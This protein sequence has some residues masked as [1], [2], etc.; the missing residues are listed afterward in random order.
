VTAWNV[1]VLSAAGVPQQGELL[2]RPGGQRIVHATA[3]G[4]VGAAPPSELPVSGGGLTFSRVGGATAYPD[5]ALLSEPGPGPS[6]GGAVCESSELTT[7]LEDDG[8]VYHLLRLR[9]AGWLLPRFRVVVPGA[10]KV[11]AARVDGNWLDRL[12]VVQASEQT[13]I[14]LAVDATAAA[15]Q[16]E[17][18]YAPEPRPGGWPLVRLLSLPEPGLPVEPLQ[19]RHLW[20]LPADWVPWGTAGLRPRGQPDEIRQQPSV[21]ALLARAWHAGGPL[22]GWDPPAGGGPKSPQRQALLNAEDRLRQRRALGKGTTLGEAVDRLALELLPEPISLVIDIE[23][24]RAEGLEPRSPLPEGAA[25]AGRPFADAVGLVYVFCPSGL[26]LTTPKRVRDWQEQV[27]SPARLGEVLDPEV[28]QAAAVG[29]DHAGCFASVP[30]WLRRPATAASPSTS[31]AGQILLRLAG[32]PDAD[33]TEW[34]PLSG[35]RSP[36][37]LAVIH[38]PAWRLIGYVLACAWVLAAWA[39]GRRLSPAGA[40]R[41]HLVAFGVLG[42]AVLWLPGPPRELVAAPLLLAEALAFAVTFFARIW[43][44]RGPLGPG[45]STMVRPAGATALLALALAVPALV[46]QPPATGAEPYPVYL[47]PGAEGGA[48]FALVPPELLKKLDEMEARAGSAPAGGVVVAARYQG[49]VNEGS[50]TVEAQF[51]LYHFTEKSTFVLPLAGVNL[52]KGVF[53]DGFPAF[54]V[55]HKGGYALPLRGKGF[56]RLT[57]SFQAPAGVV[58]D[59]QELHFGV[60]RAGQC[61]L[62][63][64]WAGPARGIGLTGGLGAQQLQADAR[65]APTLRAQL[66]HEGLVQVRWPAA[67]PPPSA[68]AVEVR[69]AY[70]WDLR[71]AAPGLTG[72]VQFTVTKGSL[73]QLRL[74][75]P[76]GLEVR[77][78]EPA[79][80]PAMTTAAPAVRRWEVVGKD[81]GRQ[82]VVDF[83]QPVSG[84]VALVIEMVPRLALVP[85]NWLLR[86]PAPV[87]GTTTEGLL[88]YRLEGADAVPS[89]Q[90]LSVATVPA[91]VFGKTW[92]KLTQRDPPAPGKALSF[93]RMAPA[94]ALGLAVRPARPAA[95]ADL[96]WKVGPRHADLT[97]QVQ[98]S[99]ATEDVL[100]VEIDLP[101]RFKLAA[102]TGPQ[103]HHWGRQG[104]RVQVWMQQPRRQVNLEVRG[105]VD[106]P[107]GKDG[108]FELAPLRIPRARAVVS[109]VLV[110][111]APG[112]A[113]T[114]DRVVRLSHTGPADELRFTSEESNYEATFTLRPA[115]VPAAGRAFTLVEQRGDVAEVTTALHL[116]A[117]PGPVRVVV[118]G[119]TGGELRLE[120]P[121]PVARKGHQ[122]HGAEHVWALDFPAGLPQQVTLT[123]HGRLA[124]DRPIESW[125]LPA[126][127]VEPIPL[128]DH[129]VGLV[130]VEPAGKGGPALKLLT[131]SAKVFADYPAP[132]RELAATAKVGRLPDGPAAPALKVPPPAAADQ[133]QVL[134]ARE[135]TCWDE[136]AG[137]VHELQVLAFSRGG[138][139]LHLTLPP[140]VRCRAV[141]I[142][143]KVVAPPAPAGPELAIPL[144]GQPGPQSVQVVWTDAEDHEPPAMPRLDRPA[145]AGL[146]P[147]DFQGRF[148]LPAAYQLA[149][150]P[151]GLAE[152]AADLL[153][154]EADARMRL[155]A[156]WAAA[157]A[158]ADGLRRQ[159]GQFFACLKH[160]RSTID[161]LQ[162]SGDVSRAAEL[163]RKEKDL[164]EENLRLAQQGG[165]EPLAR[166]AED[167]PPGAGVPAFAPLAARENG[168]PICWRAGGPPADQPLPLTFA[169]DREQTFA[170]PATEV[171]LLAV[172][173][174]LL[175]SYVR[176]GLV[177]L[178]TAWPEAILASALLGL[179]LWGPSLVGLLLVSVAITLRVTWLVEAVR[180]ALARRLARPP[181]GADGE[182]EPTA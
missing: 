30:H 29:V 11:L 109:S 137:W 58:N 130:G 108:R 65:G 123:L 132:P 120:T 39:V 41:A 163:A 24:L 54:P 96:V 60:P 99:A 97:A 126:I 64:T 170:P 129:W 118:S 28:A 26:L 16:V 92:A 175:I 45:K 74:A 104:D 53:L 150:L 22:P 86:L 111:P 154:H 155:A 56:H 57:L 121:A 148:W 90:N 180:Q 70:Y 147:A 127:R 124:A 114:A 67:A 6:A 33:A 101:P 162:W 72:V 62:E 88:A 122:H 100:L 47:I 173:V 105:W 182:R 136:G 63:L 77:S 40:F 153:L 15:Q 13:V 110:E 50:A 66:G 78:V 87:Q 161:V 107:P 10:V 35:L 85:G 44:A 103:V 119:W 5:L 115:P 73:P 80:R 168:L 140:G 18:L 25:Q 48:E 135:E 31:D 4:L 89:A 165:Y 113:L 142:G 176:R 177:L 59:Y 141:A 8:S 23:G 164:R 144:P 156:R 167:G 9:L 98:L 17:L 169:P 158:P 179:W 21:P 20:R 75:L 81:P 139:E 159:Q 117:R 52:Q 125:A 146:D 128:R 84:T 2:V 131:A 143:G 34:E 181:A 36:G 51:D 71:P 157:G 42:L 171:M 178:R 106:H 112:L 94:A 134:F 160:A 82:L 1:P 61:E 152:R 46:A 149:D 43:M 166:E 95:K 68:K 133:P 49:R 38:I 172:V 93:R 37:V 19:T 12:E 91:E 151:A 32:P 83:G 145:V 138:G 79:A 174:L 69:E 3:H 27:G 102:V 14:V 7:A 55:A 76:E 116:Q